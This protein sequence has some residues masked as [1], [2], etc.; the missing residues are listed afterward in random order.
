MRAVIQDVADSS[1]MTSSF[2]EDPSPFFESVLPTTL[3]GK[4]EKRGNS[5]FSLV[6]TLLA[7]AEKN[8]VFRLRERE[9]S[10]CP[11]LIH[12]LLKCFVLKFQ[13][14]GQDPEL[15]FFS[16]QMHCLLSWRVMC[17]SP[18]RQLPPNEVLSL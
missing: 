8:A 9:S 10:C 4:G 6:L 16:P 14:S 2:R 13:K 5:Y 18:H 3:L 1:F 17:V 11:L 15:I 7:E 12:E